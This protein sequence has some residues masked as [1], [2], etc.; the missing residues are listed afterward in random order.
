MNFS[1]E[2]DRKFVFVRD[3]GAPC[4]CEQYFRPG[5]SLQNFRI[6]KFYPGKKKFSHKKEVCEEKIV[7]WKSGFVDGNEF[8]NFFWRHNEYSTKENIQSEKLSKV[9]AS[10]KKFI[11]ATVEEEPRM[12][13]IIVVRQ[14]VALLV[15]VRFIRNFQ[16]RSRIFLVA[17]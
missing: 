16:I 6:A 15:I 11:I 5:Y 8:E 9:F 10:R 4:N 1:C 17:R 7:Q 12:F 2:S 13:I 3:W 14:N